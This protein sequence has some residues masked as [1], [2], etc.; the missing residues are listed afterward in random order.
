MT[1]ILKPN[2]FLKFTEFY[3]NQ[4]ENL[5]TIMSLLN[6]S[7]SKI[8]YKAIE[9]LYLCFLDIEYRSDIIKALML[10]N[11][12][13]FEKYFDKITELFQDE[14]LIEKKN[15]ILYELEKLKNNE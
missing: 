12:T 9:I 6:H 11:K 10:K 3:F 14:D 15:F 13:N 1:L 7:C 5:M 2:D 8:K 4:K